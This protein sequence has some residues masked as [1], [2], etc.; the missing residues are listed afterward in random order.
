MYDLIPPIYPDEILCSIISR[1]NRVNGI[2][3][4][5]Y[6]SEQLY[7][8]PFIQENSIDF[9]ISIGYIAEKFYKKNNI[10]YFVQNHTLYPVF[11]P[12]MPRKGQE[13]VNNS[14]RSD[15][16][17][18]YINPIINPKHELKYCP[19]CV[20]ED[21]MNYGEAYF[22]RTHQVPYINL[23]VKHMCMLYKYE[24]NA[25]KT[26]N[27]VCID[28]NNINFN[29]ILY[30]RLV[31]THNMSIGMT[32]ACNVMFRNT[33]HIPNKESI[34]SRFRSLGPTL[35]K[36]APD[37]YTFVN[38]NFERYFLNRSLFSPRMHSD[39]YNILF[40]NP[41]AYSD[42]YK[43]LYTIFLLTKGEVEKFIYY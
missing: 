37:I 12:F 36:K 17:N 3:N 34:T 26:L 25:K 32:A 33:I 1:L 2:K 30:N 22:H 42:P 5:K 10:I 28:E 7:S 35:L 11:I 21:I 41:H 23:C 18:Y 19:L 27:Y 15:E 14:I 39:S 40:N 38:Q 20:K 31:E 8:T 29:T 16:P 6:I 43:L 24:H 9:P 13:E 4:L